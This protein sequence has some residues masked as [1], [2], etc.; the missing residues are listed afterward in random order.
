MADTKKR[1]LR[2]LRGLRPE[3]FQHPEDVDTIERLKAIP[4]MDTVVTKVM[5]QI[6]LAAPNATVNLA[7]KL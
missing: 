5:E 2:T 3:H 1:Q 4:G 6:K 7:S